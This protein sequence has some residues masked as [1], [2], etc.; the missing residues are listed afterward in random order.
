L[1]VLGAI[2]SLLSAAAFALNNASVRRGVISG[3]PIQ[4]MAISVPL[5]VICF[6]PI[7]LLAGEFGAIARFPHQAAAWMA[8]LGV[9]HFVI[10]RYFNFKANQV[11]GTNLTAPVIQ[12]QAV[13]TMVLAVTILHEPCTLLQAFGGVVMVAGSLVTQRQ[14]PQT[15]AT[16]PP[17]RE[18]GDAGLPP[19]IPLYLAGYVFSI[20]AAVAYGTTPIM[21]RFALAHT[22]PSTGLIGG[23]I[24]YVAATI[25]VGLIFL[26]SPSLRRNASGLKLANA[27]WFA[28]SGVLV[29]AAQGFFFCAVALA[30]VLFVMP[31]MQTS[32]AFRMLFSTWLS[33]HHEV[34]GALVLAGVAISLIGALLVSMDSAFIVG[35]VPLPEALARFLLW[36]V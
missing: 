13:V 31:L 19:F 34:Y 18:S 29:A 35:A 5:G 33:P 12:L 28:F 4:A 30:P 23:L 10:G 11:A 36:R 24:A 16:P 27:R 25:I 20:G 2:F 1:D 6:L 22:G 32:L 26:A 3:T 14:P 21:A 8:G 15:A 17:K 7:V 9:L